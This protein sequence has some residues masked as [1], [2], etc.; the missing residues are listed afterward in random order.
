MPQKS[1]AFPPDPTPTVH[2]GGALSVLSY[3]VEGLPWPLTHGRTQA[4]ARIA[5]QLQALRRLGQEPHVIAV[6]EAFG[7]AQKAIGAA[8]GYRYAA[9][10]PSAAFNSSPLTTATERTFI[11]Q[12]EALHGETEGAFED[13]GLAIFSDYPILGVERVA[14]P[15]YACAGYDCLANKGILAVA[16][17]V[18]GR[19]A[20]LIVLDTHLNSRTAS[21]VG[22]AR[23][24]QAYQRQVDMVGDVVGRLGGTGSQV[25]LA[26]DFNVGDDPARLSYLSQVLD[27]SKQMKVAASEMTCGA[28]CRVVSRAPTVSRSKTI[29]FYRGPT[30]ISKAGWEFGNLADGEH[31]SDH[32]GVEQGF[33]VRS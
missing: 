7:T 4:A 32:V 1:I 9:F 27:G 5:Q 31:L 15:R 13:S 17:R 3:N 26:G 28:E 25:V 30:P 20:P 6:Q 8:A 29:I 23:S 16:L 24:L 11:A 14:F 21:G 10:G 12:A 33:Q 18:P 22:E 2:L 19:T